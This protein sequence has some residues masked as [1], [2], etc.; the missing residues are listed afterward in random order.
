MPTEH[1]TRQR[2]LSLIRASTG[3][4]LRELGRLTGLS[5]A[6]LRRHVTALKRDGLV[7]CEVV[8]HSVGRPSCVYR[9]MGKAVRYE[10]YSEF[11][12]LVYT[13]MQQEGQAPVEAR[14]QRIACQIASLHPEI[15]LL[16]DCSQR[17]E[18]ARRV[19]FG[20]VD[21]T[22]TVIADG[23]CEFSLHTCPLAPIALEF[24]ELC[25]LARAVLSELV[26]AE[27]EQS[28]WIIRGDP[29]CTFEISASPQNDRSQ[30]A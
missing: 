18:A 27:V 16:P 6:S 28:E 24:R 9:V 22:P 1:P 13:A 4:T 10:R 8:H 14:F 12:R 19:V 3:V 5:R 17:L 2:L 26:G 20:D 30:I 21:S 25:G 11:L 7:D 23:R 15:R 29:R